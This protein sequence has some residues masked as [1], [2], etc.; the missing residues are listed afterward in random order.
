MGNRKNSDL[1]RDLVPHPRY[2]NRVVPSGVEVYLPALKRSYLQYGIERIFPE[3]AIRADVTKQQFSFAPREY[4]VDILKRCRTC[5]RRFLFFA[6]EQKHWYETLQFYIY[7]DCVLCPECRHSDQVLR[8][9][10]KRYSENVNRTDLKDRQL[11]GLLED[12]VF[13]FENGLLRN[14]QQL[15]RLRNLARKRIPSYQAVRAIERVISAAH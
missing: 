3:S 11:A 8:R 6:R 14:Q 15:R 4:Y 1:P 5:G 2:G 12:A 7:A 13:L 9:R 10:F